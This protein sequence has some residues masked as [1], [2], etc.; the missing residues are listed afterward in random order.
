MRMASDMEILELWA[1][2]TDRRR[3]P[4]H[5][6]GLMKT[7]VLAHLKPV[8]RPCFSLDGG[9]ANF[10]LS[11]IECRHHA[12]FSSNSS[13][14]QHRDWTLRALGVTLSSGGRTNYCHPR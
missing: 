8:V 5:A 14:G 3:R 2:S 11:A 4:V 7:R 12:V 6:A 10:K 9:V 13:P 1:R